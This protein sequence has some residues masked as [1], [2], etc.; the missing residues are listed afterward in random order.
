MDEFPH[1]YDYCLILDEQKRAEQELEELKNPEKQLQKIKKFFANIGADPLKNQWIAETEQNLSSETDDENNSMHQLKRDIKIGTIM[2][3]AVENQDNA[4]IAAL[5]AYSSDD[6]Y[7][8]IVADIM[9]YI[10]VSKG[11][12]DIKMIKRSY[13]A[14]LKKYPLSNVSDFEEGYFYYGYLIKCMR[15]Y[16]FTFPSRYEDIKE[17]QDKL[18]NLRLTLN[19]YKEDIY[20]GERV[21]DIL[22]VVIEAQ[23][24]ITE[25][26]GH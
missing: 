5:Q 15:E 22:K 19:L 18:L 7:K 4:S 14:I 9:F 26:I 3:N 6:Y 24:E 17:I 21:A 1:Y 20:I 2:K 16:A 23:D 8:L 10:G 12:S 25:L 11:K 13:D